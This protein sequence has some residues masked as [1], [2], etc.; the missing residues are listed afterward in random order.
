MQSV[1]VWSIEHDTTKSFGLNR[2][3][4]GEIFGSWQEELYHELIIRDYI[5][6]KS[7]PKAVAFDV[8]EYVCTALW[9]VWG[10]DTVEE[11]CNNQ[12]RPN[13]LV[14]MSRKSYLLTG[15]KC[16]G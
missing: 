16:M 4:Y 12:K 6:K 7:T 3:Q 2:R 1:G 10:H 9:K 13:L 11:G 5:F 14:K 15:P 8:G